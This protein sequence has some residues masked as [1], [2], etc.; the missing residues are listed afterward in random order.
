MLQVTLNKE[1]SLV[2]LEPHGE[3]SES[4]FTEVAKIIDPYI[5]EVGKIRGIIIKTEFFPGWNSFSALISHLNFVQEHH[6]KVSYIAL[7]TDSMLGDFAEHIVS[8]FISAKVQHFAYD[9]LDEAKKWILDSSLGIVQHGVSI[10]IERIDDNFLLSFCAIGRLTHEDY[11]KITPIIDLALQGVK[12]P[13]LNVFTDISQLDGWE[14]RAAWDD[15][16]IGLKYAYDFDKIAIYGQQSWLKYGV[17]ISSWFTSGEVK[18]FNSK[19]EAFN[20]LRT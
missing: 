17:I 19:E 16:K 14:L 8:H 1:D 7:V 2:I 12:E 3:L 4:D 18:Q 11:E 20:W 10:S 6:K 15:F 9:A 5:I 13:K